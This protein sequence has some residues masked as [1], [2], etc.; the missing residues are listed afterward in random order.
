MFRVSC[1]TQW[2]HA[3]FGDVATCIA[4]LAHAAVPMLGSAI[5]AISHNYFFFIRQGEIVV[6]SAMKRVFSLRNKLRAHA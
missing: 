5:V 6:G 3:R 2:I 1:V 4:I